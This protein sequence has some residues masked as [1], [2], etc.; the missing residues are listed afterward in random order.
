MII[1]KYLLLFKVA[2][3]AIIDERLSPLFEQN[4]AR[5]YVNKSDNFPIDDEWFR[6]HS[7]NGYLFGNGPQFEMIAG[8]TVRWYL[9]SLGQEIDIHTA[10]WHAETVVSQMRRDDVVELTVS[11]SLCLSHFVCLLVLLICTL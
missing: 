1:L 8:Q 5:Q 6:K 7:I 11:F 3:F 2:Y 9:Y 10:H 4:F